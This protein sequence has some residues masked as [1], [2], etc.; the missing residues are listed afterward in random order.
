MRINT[1]QFNADR[2]RKGRPLYP[3]AMFHGLLQTLG[4]R[5]VS[6]LD[7][8]CGAGQSTR[9]FLALGIAREGFAVDPDPR[10]IAAA[11]DSMNDEYLG[12]SFR[13]GRAEAIP[14]TNA[15]VDLVLVGSAFHWFDPDP[16]RLEIERVL[17]PEGLLCV[18]EYQFPKCLDRPEL[19]ETVRRRFNLEWKAPIQK[20]RGTLADLLA[21]FRANG[22]A[23][24]RDD[25]PEWTERLDS[26]AFLG[27][28]FSQSRYL[29][30]EAATVD[31]QGYRKEI[32][33]SLRPYF[34]GSALTF[35]LKPR[36]IVLKR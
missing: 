20:P 22:W 32:T 1:P 36:A 25:R 11:R 35:D 30:A 15:A 7:L 5:S 29:H 16:A 33:A 8:G 24:V 21:P 27:H 28:L 13:E 14:L 26:D 17:R 2:Y 3:P 10:M 4:E 19:A 31:P 34:E 9:S 23:V 6:F 12:V 18:F